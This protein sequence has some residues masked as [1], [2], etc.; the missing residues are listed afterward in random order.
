MKTRLNLTIDNSL[1]ENMKGYAVKQQTSVSELV[2]GYFKTVTKS[3]KRK[4]I[5]DLVEQLDKPV[6]ENDAD[7]K[8]LYY[9]AKSKK[10][11]F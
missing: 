5:I 1:L 9:Q 2:E 10:N 7:L 8:D 6:I 11:G 3:S 4:N